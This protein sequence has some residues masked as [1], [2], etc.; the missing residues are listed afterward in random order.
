MTWYKKGSWNC[1]CDICGVQYKADQLRK[2]WKGLYVCPSDYETRQPLEFIRARSED[3]TV[4]FSRPES[5]D[6]YIET[7]C[8]YWSSSQM[9]DFGTAD[10]MYIGG[11]TSIERLIE[12]YGATSRAGIA[13][14]G[15]SISGVL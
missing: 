8:D 9:A 12:I 4:P 14:S 7:T 1:L 5:E 10:C 2:N 11:N 15:R 6:E 3:T 13:I